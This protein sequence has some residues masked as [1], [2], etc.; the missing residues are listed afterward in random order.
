MA[1]GQKGSYATTTN[2]QDPLLGVLQN[3]EEQGLKYRAEQK[4]K[5]D[6]KA[7]EKKDKETAEVDDIANIKGITTNYA[8]KNGMIISAVT[9]LKDKLREKQLDLKAGRISQ[10]DYNVAKDNAMS[11]MEFINQGSKRLNEQYSS[12]AKLISEGKT[13]EGFDEGILSLGGALDKNNLYFDLKD[14]MT[15]DVIAYDNADP[16]NPKIIEKNDLRNFGVET[17]KP[18]LKYDFDGEKQEFLKSYPKVL[19]EQ[20]VGNTK[21]G[22]KGIAPEI[23]DAIDLK[24]NSIV[25]NPNALAIKAREITG[26]AK[27]DIK[28]PEIIEQ[29]RENLKTE[30]KGLYAPEKMVDEAVGRGN[31]SLGWSRLNKETQAVKIGQVEIPETITS[32]GVVISPGYKGVSVVGG[33]PFNIIAG[34]TLATV[35]SYSVKENKDG[36]KQVV[37]EITYPDVK[38][39]TL[40]KKE[41]SLLEQL[42]Q[43]PGSL[44]TEDQLEVSRIMKGVE[45]KVAVVTLDEADSFKLAKQVGLKDQYEVMNSAK[46]KNVPKKQKPSKP[47]ETKKSMTIKRSD[48]ASKAKASGYSEKEYE[49]LLKEKGIKIE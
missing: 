2:I 27:P 25:S 38:S 35:N 14:D 20:F 33:K 39:A 15:F 18:V 28:D 19:N 31:L 1:I 32:S 16:N 26:E 48:I 43:S 47:T 8:T 4:I 12:M 5:D 3:V 46:Y 30:Y 49:K 22:K 29:V 7:K 24:V 36:R 45:N 40:S 9:K 10:T 37:A 42:S 34:K 13:A 11:Q 23:E 17:L 21:V 6:A 41:K 44:T